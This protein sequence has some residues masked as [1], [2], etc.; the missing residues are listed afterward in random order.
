SGQQVDEI[1]LV[2]VDDLDARRSR[3]QVAARGLS[4]PPACSKTPAKL[5]NGSRRAKACVIDVGR[6]LHALARYAD[7][8][9]TLHA[10]SRLQCLRMLRRQSYAQPTGQRVSHLRLGVVKTPVDIAGVNHIFVSN[11]ELDSLVSE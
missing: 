5:K 8:E 11:V 3:A 9:A 10:K 6:E 2:L 4:Q 7:Q 1:E